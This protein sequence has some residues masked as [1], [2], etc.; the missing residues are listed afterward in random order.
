MKR[1]KEQ[2][3]QKYSLADIFDKTIKMIKHTWKDSIVLSAAGFIP[4]AVMMGAAL[5]YYIDAIITMISTTGAAYDS[6]AFNWE[7]F[8][9][10][11]LAV[12][13]FFLAA[14]VYAFAA[15]FI[16]ACVSLKTYKKAGGKDRFT[17]KSRR[18]IFYR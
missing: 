17:D 11:L 13:L 12:G 18:K 16:S 14:L 4:Y 10:L 9:P 2:Y 7:I 5:Y 6:H 15:L 1:K 8:G 3:I